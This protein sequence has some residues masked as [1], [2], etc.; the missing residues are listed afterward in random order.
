MHECESGLR[1]SRR[2]LL[3]G[4]T[5]TIIAGTASTG[6]AQGTADPRLV[7]INAIGGLDGLATIIPYADQSL[8]GLRAG[9]IPKGIVKVDALFA[10]HPALVNFGAMLRA[11][12]A[13]AVHAV[14]PPVATRSHFLGQDYLQSGAGEILPSG[15]LNRA[16]TYSSAPSGGL[17]I[18]AQ[19]PLLMQ[20][21]PVVGG[22]AP[23]PFPQINPTLIPYLQ[24]LM[25]ADP[26]LSVAQQTA[27]ADR[28]IYNGILGTTTNLSAGDLPTLANLAGSL[29]ASPM[30]PRIV[31]LE[32]SSVDTHS[33]QL[34]RIGPMLSDIDNA[35]GALKTALGS[36][37]ANTVVMTMTEFGRTAYENGTEGSDHGTAFAVLLAGGAVAGGRIIAD[38]PGL[39][40]ADLYQGRDLAPTVDFRS[41]ALG[42]LNGH[43]G[44]PTSAQ[45][46]IFPGSSAIIPL[47]G[48]VTG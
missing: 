47:A 5:A 44:I 24:Q 29:L 6:R 30:G 45:E 26:L 42:V 7:V 25:S 8:A 40:T 13:C 35:L 2:M 12:E 48:L 20:G 17:S 31:G 39:T 16:I 11:G 3:G 46:M 4:A 1:L 10:L 14:G 36:A 41:I 37:W 34:S 18:G 9:L 28:A 38:W 33:S 19:V 23:E 27:F 43:L 32:T 21:I 15:W 22:Y